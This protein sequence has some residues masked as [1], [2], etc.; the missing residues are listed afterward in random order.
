MGLLRSGEKRRGHENHQAELGY[1]DLPLTLEA[2][3]RR[4]EPRKGAGQLTVAGGTRTAWKSAAF[5]ALVG[6]RRYTLFLRSPFE[7]A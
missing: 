6:V 7:F 4:L 1:F 3:D 5:L 2:R